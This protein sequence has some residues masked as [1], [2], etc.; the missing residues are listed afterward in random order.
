MR[1]CPSWEAS[2][3]PAIQDIPHILWNPL[4]DYFTMGTGSSLG[5][6]RPGRVVDHPAHLAPRLKKEQS[7][8]S[9][10]LWAFVACSRVSF[11]F[12]FTLLTTL[13]RSSRHQSLSLARLIQS[14]QC[15]AIHLCFHFNSSV[16]IIRSFLDMWY[17]QQWMSEILSY[18]NLKNR[19]LSRLMFDRRQVLVNVATSSVAQKR[20]GVYCV[21][22]NWVLTASVCI[23]T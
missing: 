11:T 1:H 16:N 15:A 22:T 14:L 13:F 17:S 4:I 12:T 19:F 6:K 5:V 10:P 3:S 7:Y 20:I 23:H 21:L 9:T 2:C 8:T 18:G